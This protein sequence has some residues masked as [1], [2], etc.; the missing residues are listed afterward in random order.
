MQLMRPNP[1]KRESEMKKKTWT[2]SV[3]VNGMNDIDIWIY[4]DAVSISMAVFSI[5]YD[6]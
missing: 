5:A 2:R 4:C 3:H 1:I 6:F